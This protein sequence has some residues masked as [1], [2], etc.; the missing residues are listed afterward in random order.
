VS[1]SARSVRS[2]DRRLQG[3]ARGLGGRA[4]ELREDDQDEGP[5]GGVQRDG[6][7]VLAP[8][9]QATGGELLEADLGQAGVDGATGGS[10]TAE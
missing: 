1:S 8:A 7:A 4:Q 9:G 6:D 2:C 5:Y 3:V 10:G